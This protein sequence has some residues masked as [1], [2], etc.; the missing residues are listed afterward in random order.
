MNTI[1]ISIVGGSPL[2]NGKSG[3]VTMITCDCSGTLISFATTRAAGCSDVSP[4][5]QGI[6][7]AV[8]ADFWIEN[9]LRPPSKNFRVLGPQP[10]LLEPTISRR[11]SP[12]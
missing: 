3:I 4:S 1:Y 2:F 8:V 12:P 5:E 11:H 6:A 7:S 10:P 9:H